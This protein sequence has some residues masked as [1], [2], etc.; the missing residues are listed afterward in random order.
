MYKVKVF[1]IFEDPLS[2]DPLIHA[3]DEPKRGPKQTGRY[4]IYK[5]R[6]YLTNLLRIYIYED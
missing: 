1:E 3:S 4:V 2:L 6:E 5:N